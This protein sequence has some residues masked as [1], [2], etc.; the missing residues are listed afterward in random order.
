MRYLVSATGVP[1]SWEDDGKELSACLWCAK[2]SRQNGTHGF[3]LTAQTRLIGEAGKPNV[4]RIT[5]PDGFA[6]DYE[7][8]D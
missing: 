6:V 4:T 7:P 1:A 5:Y 2:I 3:R 8:I